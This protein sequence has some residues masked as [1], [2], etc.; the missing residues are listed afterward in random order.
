M[1]APGDVGAARRGRR[2]LRPGHLRDDSGE[3][4][5]SEAPVG[6]RSFL[7]DRLARPSPSRSATAP[8]CFWPPGAGC[9]SVR[10]WH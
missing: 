5:T 6:R 10:R 2:R 9:A 8:W 7:T 4:L 3:I 1:P